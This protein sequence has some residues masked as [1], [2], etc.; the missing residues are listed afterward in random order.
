MK[1]TVGIIVSHNLGSFEN[2]LVSFIRRE[3]VWKDLEMFGVLIPE[4]VQE[5][6]DKEEVCTFYNLLETERTRT[7]RVL[8]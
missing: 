6:Q 7:P 2:Y 3:D 8:I 4:W 1:A 5:G